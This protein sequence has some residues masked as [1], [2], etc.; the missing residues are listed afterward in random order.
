MHGD[1]NNGYLQ[2]VS[3]KRFFLC[4]TIFFVF[5]IFLQ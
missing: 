5:N 3:Y 1:V 2:L 4:F